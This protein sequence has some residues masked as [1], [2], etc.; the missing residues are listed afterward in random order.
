MSGGAFDYKQHNISMIA[1]EIEQA[2]RDSGRPKTPKELRDESWG[3]DASWYEKYPEDLNHYAYPDDI[4]EEFKR[5]LYIMRQAYIYA[6]RIDWLMSGDDGDDSFR[7]RLRAEL[8]T[9][10]NAPKC[11]L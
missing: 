11:W 3:R 6:Q 1:D 10:E 8:D 5:G 2:I 9:L 7:T 4:I